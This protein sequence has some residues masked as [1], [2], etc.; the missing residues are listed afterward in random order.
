MAAGKLRDVSLWQPE[1][2]T[3]NR[4]DGTTLI[5][6]K[7]P[8][9]PHADRITDRVIHWA[10]ETPDRVWMAQRGDS[11]AWRKITYAELARTMRHLGQA[12]LDLDLSVDRPVLILSGNSLEHAL[13]AL[14][15]Q[16]VGIASAAI[17]PAY[18]LVST[19]YAKLKDIMGLVTPGLIFAQKGAPFAKAIAATVPLD[20]PVLSV[21]EPVE[22]GHPTP[23]WTDLIATAPTEAVTNA[24]QA[25]TPDSIAKFLFTSGTTG[26]PKAVIQTHRMLCANQEMIL[27]CYAFMKDEPPIL[28]DWAPWNHTASGNKAFNIAIYH[29]G[30]YYI[31]EGKPTADGMKE[32]IR[33]LREISP[34]WYFN[35]PAGLEL[36]VEAMEGDVELRTS[37]FRNLRLLM[38]AGAG[39][40]AHTWTRLKSLSEETVGERILLTTGLG[41]TETAPFSLYCTEEQEFPG[42]VGIPARGVTM[43][44]VPTGDKLELRLKGP[45]IT[46]GYWRSPD[47]TK[48]AFDDEGFYRIGDALRFAEEGNPSKGFYFDGRIAENFKLRTGTWVAVGPL[49]AQL[50]DQMAGLVRD[51]VITGEN[52][53]DLAAILIPFMPALRALADDSGDLDDAAVMALPAVRNAIA[54]R[55]AEHRARATGSATRV[56]RVLLLQDPL[57]LDKGEVTD[58]GSVNQRAVIRNRSHLVKMLHETGD[59]RVIQP[60]KHGEPV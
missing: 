59:P 23:A 4:P 44:L 57:A 26:S 33:N 10:L 36:L 16:H 38:Y 7:D 2:A 54:D 6:R 14:A 18:S 34:T 56:N 53:T 51:V 27:D 35:V 31:D 25:V 19:D 13:L 40:G 21:E 24:H 1:L 12:L 8:L 29:G 47:L 37:F 45:N 30:T 22:T 5:W 55:L 42:N 46:P 15:A 17:S 49:R 58:K 48:A 20:V 43:K 3:E 28:V 50:L 32:T 39:L 52:E 60:S 9:P 41:S 11:G